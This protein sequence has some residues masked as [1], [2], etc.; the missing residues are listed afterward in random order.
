M[1]LLVLFLFIRLFFVSYGRDFYEGKFVEEENVGGQWVLLEQTTKK[2]MSN[3]T[4]RFT[5]IRG[6]T[7]QAAENK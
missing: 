1:L 2:A 6:K 4:S 7:G 3:L 5:F